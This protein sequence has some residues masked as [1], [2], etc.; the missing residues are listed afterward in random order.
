MLLDSLMQIQQWH[1]G[2]ATVACTGVAQKQLILCLS[3]RTCEQA[4]TDRGKLKASN[5]SEVLGSPAE[6]AWRLTCSSKACHRN[7]LGCTSHPPRA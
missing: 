5:S 3:S 7:H 1:W 6:Q 4:G 2:K